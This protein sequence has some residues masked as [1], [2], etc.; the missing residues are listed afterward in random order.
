M[1]QR[2]DERTP[3]RP[4]SRKGRLRCEMEQSFARAGVPTIVLRAGDFIERQKTGNWFDSHI[5]AKIDRRR[6]M[7]PGPL[8]R[9]H[10]WAFLPDMARAMVGLAERRADWARFEEFGFAGYSLSGGE[11]VAAIESAAGQSLKV[12]GL[13][14]PLVRLAGMVVPQF[15]EVAEM[16]YLWRV[17]HAI[18]GSKLARALPE[19]LPTPLAVAMAEA[20]ADV[21]GKAVA[22]LSRAA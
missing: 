13:P 22:S 2:L 15:R 5:T 18:D 9:V 14:W 1:P 4:T 16:S 3:Q 12:N 10:A 20:L 8:D 21:S 19:F 7:Y 11:L 6:L 17:S